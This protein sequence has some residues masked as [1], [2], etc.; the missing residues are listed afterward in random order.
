MVNP[1]KE[2]IWQ[3]LDSL[4]DPE[5]PV[6]SIVE[7]GMVRDVEVVGDNVVV[8]VTPT[9]TG[10]PA[11]K[12]IEDDIMK[13]L[14]GKGIAHPQVK[15][16][17]SPAWTTDWITSEA[18]KKL[19]DYGITPPPVSTEDKGALLDTPK[20][21]RCPRCKSTNTLLKS[22]FGSTPCKALYICSDCLE[23]FD[24]FKCI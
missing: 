8:T 16:V 14:S 3:W 7:L 17:N 2:T 10:C 19:M 12:M 22:Q 20:E 13:L 4:P 21:V 6:I 11:V 18:K 5:I 23:P 24:Y 15:S 9:Y 1:D